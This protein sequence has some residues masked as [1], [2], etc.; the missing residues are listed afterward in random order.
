MTSI[1]VVVV[2]MA[3]LAAVVVTMAPVTAAFVAVVVTTSDVAG[4][5][6]GAE[7]TEDG[8]KKKSLEVHMCVLWL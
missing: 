3:S 2:A 1:A 7:E 8:E 5:T 4:K 6:D